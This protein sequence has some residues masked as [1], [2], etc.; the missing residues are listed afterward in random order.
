MLLLFGL[1]VFL[2]EYC[3]SQNVVQRY[4]ASRSARDAR[5]AM[6]YCAAVSVPMWA[7]FMFLGTGL[8]VFFRQF[9]TAEAERLLTG[10][11]GAEQIMPYFIISFVPPGVMGLVI[12]AALAAAMS[13]LDSSINAIATVGVVDVY[14]RHLVKN[15]RDGHYLHAARLIATVSA[16]LMMGGAILLA[17][18]ETHTLQHTSIIFVSLLGGGMLGIYLLGFFTRRG[19]ARA[20][21][22]GIACTLLFTAWTLIPRNRLPNAL[23]VPFDLYYTGVLGNAVMFSVGSFVS[24]LLP[25]RRRDLRN[26]TVWDLDPAAAHHC[27]RRM[28]TCRH[29][30]VEEESKRPPY[31]SPRLV[32]F[33]SSLQGFANRRLSSPQCTNASRTFSS[34]VPASISA[35][36]TSQGP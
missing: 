24:T 36:T 21:W 4:C 26:L 33:L 18:A 22:A 34:G 16:V 13:S 35:M 2:T 23:N 7:F 19:D 1:V 27:S 29:R 15:R 11:G 28:D 32:R 14:R 12:G 3:S 31:A 9:P 5:K 17:H 20:V 30:P 25:A 6:Y 10:A 8:Y